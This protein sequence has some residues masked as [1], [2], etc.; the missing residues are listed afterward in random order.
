ML[1][2]FFSV[3]DVK[4]SNQIAIA[5]PKRIFKRAVD[6]NRVKRIIRE[7][8]RLNNKQILVPLTVD[9]QKKLLCYLFLLGKKC[10]IID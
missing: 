9:K 2:I 4:D 6:R 10:L 5:V 1:C 3:I 7:A 8:Y